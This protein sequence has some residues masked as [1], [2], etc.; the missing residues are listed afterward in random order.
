VREDFCGDGAFVTTVADVVLLVPAEA[1]DP[2]T[3]ANRDAKNV[4]LSV[5]TG[6]RLENRPS[7]GWHSPTE[8]DITVPHRSDVGL[9]KNEH[10]GVAID[11][12]LQDNP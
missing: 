11:I 12:T 7:V 3:A 4:V 5:D 6:G 1:A 9:M 10:R 8:L 2:G